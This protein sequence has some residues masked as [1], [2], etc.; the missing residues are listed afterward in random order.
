MD[1]G[2]KKNHVKAFLQI[3]TLVNKSVTKPCKKIYSYHSQSV[4]AIASQSVNFTQDILEDSRTKNYENY[5]CCSSELGGETL[6]YYQLLGEGRFL[7]FH[8]SSWRTICPNILEYKCVTQM[9]DI[10]KMYLSFL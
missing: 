2:I 10:R 5:S 9:A 7:D 3:L 6:D 8:A 4:V 1:F